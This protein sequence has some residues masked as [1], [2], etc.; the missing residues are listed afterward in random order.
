MTQNDLALLNWAIQNLPISS[1]IK[2]LV[3]AL[4]VWEYHK[5]AIMPIAQYLLRKFSSK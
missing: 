3:H 4:A 1:D 2:V 5:V